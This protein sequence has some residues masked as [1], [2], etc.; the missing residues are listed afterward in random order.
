MSENVPSDM[1]IRA[2][3]SESW[4]DAFF[5]A[6]GTKFHHADNDKSNQTDLSRCL[7]HMSEGMFSDT[8]AQM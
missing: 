2:V 1:L 6:K 4:L 8:V 7:S 3:W 5:I